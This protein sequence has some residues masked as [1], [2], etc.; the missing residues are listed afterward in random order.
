MRKLVNRET[1]GPLRP[2]L[3]RW[4]ATVLRGQRPIEIHFLRSRGCLV[5][6]AAVRRAAFGVGLWFQI[7]HGECAFLFRWLRLVR[8][9]RHGRI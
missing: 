3:I 8:F 6:F 7:A 1:E 5:A 4:T 2:R 9:V